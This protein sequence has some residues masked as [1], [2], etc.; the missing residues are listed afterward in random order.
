MPLPLPVIIA[1]FAFLMLDKLCY[2]K[3]TNYIFYLVPLLFS[4]NLCCLN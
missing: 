3:K 4:I 2:N 1:V